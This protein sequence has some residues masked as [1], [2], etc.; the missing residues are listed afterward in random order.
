[1]SKRSSL[2]KDVLDSLL[3]KYTKKDY[4]KSDPVQF[5]HRYGDERDIEVCGFICSA[6][7]FGR[8]EKINAVIRDILRVMGRS[9]Y[10]FVKDFDAVRSGAKFRGFRYRFVK[11]GDLLLFLSYVRGILEEA[12]S[13]E[14]FYLK[15]SG[16]GKGARNALES[17]VTRALETPRRKGIPAPGERS[18]GARFLLPDPAAGSACKR[19]NLFLR[20]M[21]RSDEIDRGLWKGVSPSELVIPL[22][23]HVARVSRR[24]GLTRLKSPGWAMAESITAA[25]REFD[26]DDPVK[27]DF[28]LTRPGIIHGCRA[29]TA[30]CR[31]CELKR[32]CLA[33]KRR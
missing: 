10:R 1:M 17:F 5:L 19:L 11:E 24:I 25:L 7:A 22:D 29:G 13:I 31:R 28:A 3:E 4:L 16:R 23:T 33:C 15:G 30:L 9:P 18:G 26:S 2:T 32:I 6:F 21:V 12:G 27:Y 8:V 14:D 20:W